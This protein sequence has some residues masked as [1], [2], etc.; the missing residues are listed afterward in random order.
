VPRLC[1]FNL[2]ICLTTEEKARKTL[3]YGKKTLNGFK[4][5]LYMDIRRIKYQETAEMFIKRSLKMRTFHTMLQGRLNQ[6]G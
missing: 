4:K 1:E 6:G 2:D 5:N 3:S